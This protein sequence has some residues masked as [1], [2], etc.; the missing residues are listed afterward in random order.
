MRCFI[1]QAFQSK[2]DE[3]DIWCRDYDEQ[4]S[5]VIKRAIEKAGY[6]ELAITGLYAINC[7]RKKEYRYE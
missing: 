7:M 6:T 5:N 2:K 3:Q 1:V 4:M